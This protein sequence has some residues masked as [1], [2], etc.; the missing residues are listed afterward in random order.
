MEIAELTDVRSMNTGELTAFLAEM[1][2]PAY[3]AKQLFIWLQKGIKSFDEMT[4]IPKTLREEMKKRAYINYP[5]IEK[6]FCSRIDETKKYLIRLYDGQHIEAVLMSYHHG[7]SVCISTQV[8]CRMGCSFC[9]T[10]KSGFSRNLYPSE[11]LGQISAI[12]NAEDIKISNVVLMGMG[13]PLDNYDNVMRFLSL[14]SDP[15]GRCIGM[16]HISLSTCG[17]VDKIDQLAGQKPQFTLS[18]SLH[19][20]NDR[21]RDE[22]MPINKKWNVGKLLDSCRRYAVA[23]GRRISFEYALVSGVNDSQ[24]DAQEL[25]DRVKGMLCHVNLIP[26]NN[27]EGS[28]CREPDRDRIDA[29]CETLNRRGV[30]ATIRRTLGS[31][32]SASCGQ[33]RR[34]EL[35]TVE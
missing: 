30:T 14:L 29:F 33:L 6:R 12:E 26:V 10:G 25:A 15:D 9:A 21:I 34:R 23:T 11:M 22:M 16:R 32:I 18:V 17:L 24:R 31:D 19:A 35:K 13:E 2:Q 7:Y 5:E 8:G 20:P 28:E 27:V 1:G 3:R 4:N